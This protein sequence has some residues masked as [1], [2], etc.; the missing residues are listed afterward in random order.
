MYDQ[1]PWRGIPVVPSEL[2]L[3]PRWFP[4][5]LNKVS[6]WSRTVMVP[7]SILCT[8]KARAVN[9]R[10]VDIR[11]L[12]IVAPE[13]E[14]NY[15]PPAETPLKRFFMF[16]ERILSRVEPFVPKSLRHYAIRR[17]DVLYF[18]NFSRVF[19]QPWSMHMKL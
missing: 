5:S 12:F 8:L 9:P 16:V 3:L 11:E 18:F 13:E 7:L 1:I 4:F 19:F 10:K 6:Y 15:F 17:A 2:V 14:K